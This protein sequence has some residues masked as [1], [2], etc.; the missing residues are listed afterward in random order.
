[1][2]LTQALTLARAG[3][4]GQVATA[5]LAELDRLQAEYRET[6]LALAA[7]RVEL[8]ARRHGTI[9]V[10]PAGGWMT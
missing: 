10:P 9:Q 7:A 5:L 8:T 3:T 2:D 4:A 1:M 6:L